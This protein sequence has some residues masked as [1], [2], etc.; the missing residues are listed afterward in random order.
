MFSKCRYCS[1][2]KLYLGNIFIGF[3]Q[4][5][6]KVGLGSCLRYLHCRPQNPLTAFSTFF[7]ARNFFNYGSKIQVSRDLVFT[8]VLSVTFSGNKFQ[9]PFMYLSYSPAYLILGDQSAKNFCPRKFPPV[10]RY[11]IKE[12]RICD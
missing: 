5:G 7:H 10:K 9:G 1:G 12:L 11:S 3:P 2:V 4:V 8:N 6:I